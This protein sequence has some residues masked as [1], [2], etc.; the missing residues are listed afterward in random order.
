V[1][2]GVG[3][4]IFGAVLLAACSS[5]DATAENATEAPGLSPAPPTE[6]TEIATALPPATA[7]P[8]NV[9]N[10]LDLPPDTDAVE[11]NYT[12]TAVQSSTGT[13]FQ[14]GM[15]VA[16]T[17]ER[18]TRGLMFRD[19]LPALTGMLFAFPVPTMG[20]YWAKDTPLD[21][22]VALLNENGVI[23]EILS[24]VAL[25]TELVMPGTEYL[26]GVEMPAGW[27]VE[28]SIDLGAQFD[29]P[30]SVIGFAE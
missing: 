15:L 30:E 29:I 5:S 21:L 13:V 1:R 3:L 12:R 7:I 27:F 26:Y 22:D 16:D 19:G 24:L 17:Y 10:A 18:R 23:I 14:L 6:P 11:F 4:L 28:H 9:N 2:I 8:G 20:N 25:S